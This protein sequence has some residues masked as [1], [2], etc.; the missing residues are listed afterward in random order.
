MEASP[1]L[2]K[3]GRAAGECQHDCGNRLAPADLK[4]CHR[5]SAA[6]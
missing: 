6:V 2:R 5:K 3:G 4:D 1:I